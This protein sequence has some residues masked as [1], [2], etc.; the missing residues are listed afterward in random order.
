MKSPIIF[1]AIAVFL[2]LQNCGK[3]HEAEKPR[4]IVII[5]DGL[6]SDAIENARLVHLQ[7]WLKEGSFYKEVSVPIPAH[8]ADNPGYLWSCSIP[9]AVMMTGTV[10]IGQDGIKDA[11]IQDMFPDK[12][13]SFIVNDDA[14]GDIGKGFGSYYNLKKTNEDMFS[15]ELVFEKAQKV[16]EDE[17]PRFLRLHIQGPGSAGDESSLP[18]NIKESWY[19]NIWNRESPYLRQLRTDDQ[20]IEEFINWLQYKGY[21]VNSTMFIL[22]D[23]GQAT[24]GGHPPYDSESNKTCLLILGNN[25]RPGT[26]YDYAEM[27]DIAPTIIRINNLSPLRFSQGRIL[28]EAFK[29]G[30]DQSRV[31]RRIEKLNNILIHNQHIIFPQDS[32][33]T[34]FLTIDRICEWHKN[35]HPVTLEEFI[36]YEQ[37]NQD[38]N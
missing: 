10:F 30:P 12:K 22:G 24:T 13:T 14:Y 1:S 3:N 36:Q 21:W 35:I 33:H 8:P 19:H 16:I 17:N 32:S 11:M 2:L 38:G 23:H 25:V 18:A 7:N 9:N 15:D 26:V 5:I 27:T 29:W 28:E 37:I 6:A 34:G 20:L 31:E 4:T